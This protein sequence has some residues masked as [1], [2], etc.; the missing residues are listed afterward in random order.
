MMMFC[1]V[2]GSGSGVAIGTLTSLVFVVCNDSF[3]FDS[4][5][6]FCNCADTVSELVS[7]EAGPHPVAMTA[8]PSSKVINIYM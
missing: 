5:P 6:G 7:V 4:I 3:C 1:C 8:D 2:S